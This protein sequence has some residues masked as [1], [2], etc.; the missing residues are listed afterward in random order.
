M[1]TAP[2]LFADFQPGAPMGEHTQI[3]DELLAQRWQAIFGT[4]TADVA[5]EAA[6]A[7]GI[8]TVIMMGAYLKVVAPRP[9]GNI[10]ASQ[11]M[12]IQAL[13]QHGE[14]VRVTV[15]CANKEIRR[16][17]KYIDLQVRGT[18]TA[19]RVLFDGII[20]VIWAA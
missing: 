6:Q 11:Q 20:T 16:E 19:D 9:P 2:I 14:A 10:H 15:T 18:G 5:Q 1:S 17:R 8:L 3:Y 12:D 7:T 4:G 13:P